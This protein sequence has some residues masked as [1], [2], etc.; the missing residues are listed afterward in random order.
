MIDEKEINLLYFVK[1]VVSK[2]KFLLKATAIGFAF[3][4]IM[5]I[6]GAKEYSCEV[7]LLP[8]INTEDA[9]GSSKLLQKIGG[10]T[11]ISFDNM[12]GGLDVVRPDLYPGILASNDFMVNLMND[13]FIIENHKT[14]LKY[15]F[16][17]LKPKSPLVYLKAYTLNLPGKITALFKENNIE[18]ATEPRGHL[19]E[20]HLSE[21]E[22]L[23]IEELKKLIT[24]E[25]DFESGI[26]KLSVHMPTP[27]LTIAVADYSYSYL[28]NYMENYRSMKAQ[29]NYNF[30][31]SRTLEAKAEFENIQL[32]LAQFRD[33][34]QNMWTEKA[35]INE[36]KLLNQYDLKYSIYK[37]LAEKKE[38]LGIKVQNSK[39][40]FKVL[41][42]PTYPIK[43]S[44]PQRFLLTTVFTF[45]GLAFGIIL[46]LLQPVIQKLRSILKEIPTENK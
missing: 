20:L 12:G 19:A 5:A 34:H 33:E 26:F 28:T 23:L 42:N 18:T 43:K 38:E 35:R 2:K 25:L 1:L 39:P 13:S 6:F 4:L 10:L 14:T 36:E 46:M 22:I 8:E 29:E 24:A 37:S 41:E 27:E 16:L 7:K 21:D 9:A 3:G 30:I 11:G 45:L 31:A 15:Y 44:K 32:L 17:E 40:V